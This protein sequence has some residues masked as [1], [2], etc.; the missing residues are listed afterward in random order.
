VGV[1]D[2]TKDQIRPGLCRLGP[3][4]FK[5]QSPYMLRALV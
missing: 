5:N 2:G 4:P 3:Y 1:G